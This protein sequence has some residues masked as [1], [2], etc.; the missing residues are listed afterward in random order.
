MEWWCNGVMYLNPM[1]Q[2]SFTPTLHF[3]SV[4]G[5]LQ[6]WVEMV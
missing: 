6:P 2:Y 3:M 4:A 5:L 1:L